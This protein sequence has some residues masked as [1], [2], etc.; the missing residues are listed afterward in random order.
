MLRLNFKRNRAV[1][2]MARAQ[3]ATE[4]IAA[5]GGLLSQL[6]QFGAD[7]F[8]RGRKPEP[9]VLRVAAVVQKRKTR[10]VLR[11]QLSCRFGQDGDA[12]SFGVVARRSPTASY[13]NSLK[14][15]AAGD[16]AWPRL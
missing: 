7:H 6:S 16:S 4:S 11:R 1:A 10:W 14:L 8:L 3:A 15:A 12:A 2:L 5:P 9:D 13:R